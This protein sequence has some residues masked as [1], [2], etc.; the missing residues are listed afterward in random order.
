M[1]NSTMR[2]VLEV[3]GVH[4]HVVDRFSFFNSPYIGHRTGCAIDIYS[5]LS[6]IQGIVRSITKLRQ[7][8]LTLIEC[9]ENKDIYAK[10]LH[11]KPDLKVM[12]KVNVGDS[13]G[14]LVWSNFFNFWTDPHIHLELRNPDDA[15]RAK[16]G[17]SLVEIE[18]TQI[19]FN[20]MTIEVKLKPFGNYMIATL[21]DD[22][23]SENRGV[24]GF[25]FAEGIICGGLPHYG[26]GA[27]L[28]ERFKIFKC[29]HLDIQL[30]NMPIRGIGLYL[31]LQEINTLKLIVRPHNDFP[32]SGILS[33]KSIN[34]PINR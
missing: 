25:K 29:P 31:H 17:Y 5:S 1:T 9:S 2:E 34:E 30:N 12:D 10:L 15:I 8:Y 32:T 27:I 20:K 4:I 24:F 26:Y 33:I 28:K 18:N 23:Y 3:Q 21:P 14:T 7:D 11:I 6:P 19:E 22:Y 16:G 13:I